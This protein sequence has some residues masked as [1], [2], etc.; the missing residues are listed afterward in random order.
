MCQW[1]HPL[2]A[3]S[4]MRWPESELESVHRGTFSGLPV[5]STDSGPSVGRSYTCHC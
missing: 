3:V 5:R 1:N 2:A 4:T